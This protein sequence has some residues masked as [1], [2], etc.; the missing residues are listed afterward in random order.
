MKLDK[1]PECGC[2]IK[3]SKKEKMQRQITIQLLKSVF[4]ALPGLEATLLEAKSKCFSCFR[5]AILKEVGPMAA[6]MLGQQQAESEKEEIAGP[7]N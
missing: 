7:G 5:K 1:C 4:S 3:M 6:S 2:E